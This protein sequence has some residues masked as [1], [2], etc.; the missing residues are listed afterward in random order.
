[1]E[2]RIP[3][4]KLSPKKAGIT[5][6]A[7]VVVMLI[8]FLLKRPFAKICKASF[9]TWTQALVKSNYYNTG[10]SHCQSA[11]THNSQENPSKS[12]PYHNYIT[13][14]ENGQLFSS[15]EPPRLLRPTGNPPTI[16]EKS[17]SFRNPIEFSYNQ[18]YNMNWNKYRG[19]CNCRLRG[20]NRTSTL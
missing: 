11:T 5:F 16:P 6:A 13:W 1:M 15:R 17:P 10:H 4:A 19:A 20:S 9:S 14:F 8:S 3:S 18:V 7:A 2:T 12:I